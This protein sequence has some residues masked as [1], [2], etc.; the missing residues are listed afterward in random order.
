MDFSVLSGGAILFF[1][2]MCLHIIIW[3]WRSP[4]NYLLALLAV[5][6]IVPGALVALLVYVGH[7]HY[8]PGYFSVLDLTSVFFFHLSLVSAYILTYPAI[9]A[10]CPSMSMLLIIN[11][12]MPQ[13][14]THEKLKSSFNIEGL[15]HPRLRDLADNRFVVESDGSFSI[16]KRGVFILGFFM[17]LRLM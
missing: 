17:I 11:A 14:A 13:G 5:F 10:I 9:Q 8:T 15:L 3:R 4:E 6:L 7:F 12:S 16:T 1:G 2:S